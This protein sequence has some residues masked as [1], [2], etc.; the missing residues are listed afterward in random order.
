MGSRGTAL[1]W[2]LVVR[3]ILTSWAMMWPERI[4]K[5]NMHV[6]VIFIPG[7]IALLHNGFQLFIQ[8]RP[9]KLNGVPAARAW[10]V[11]CVQ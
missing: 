1:W 7:F 9:V 5:I 11:L 8:V 2:K 3:V 4:L 10:M 6:F